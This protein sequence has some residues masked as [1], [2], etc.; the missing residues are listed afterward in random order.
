MKPKDITIEDLPCMEEYKDLVARNVSKLEK[1]TSENFWLLRAQLEDEG[2]KYV[3]KKP[4]DEESYKKIL[5]S[6]KTVSELH[7]K[8]RQTYDFKNCIEE[9]IFQY[10][11]QG[12]EIITTQSFDDEGSIMSYTSFFVR[13]KGADQQELLKK[14]KTLEEEAQKN[15]DLYLRT[16]ADVKNTMTRLKKD[17]EEH[18]KY[19]NASLIKAILPSI[20]NF[21]RMIE[22]SKKDQ[23]LP[24]SFV[25]G[26][27]LVLNNLLSSLKKQGLEE[28]KSVGGP[29]NPE[30]HEA[31]SMQPSEETPKGHVL[32]ELQ[33]GYTLNGRLLRPSSVI[34]SKGKE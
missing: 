24:Q 23:N 31:I 5:E 15:Y 13:K 30:F 12:Y 22:Y 7:K 8:A 20:D 14:I 34:V 21:Y 9:T 4:N 17:K 1:N 10:L 3:G 19:A 25:Q 11:A 2:F 6:E 33:K 27:E 26:I 16:N 28:V 18:T 32:Q 29:F